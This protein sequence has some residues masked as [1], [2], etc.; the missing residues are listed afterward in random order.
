ME[1]RRE[2]LLPLLEAIELLLGDY[3]R[4]LEE[5]ERLQQQ[6]ALPA[7]AAPIELQGEQER[8]ERTWDRIHQLRARWPRPGESGRRTL[9]G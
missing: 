5:R 8:L 4:R 6:G 9:S 3:R 2:E 7:Q 1:T